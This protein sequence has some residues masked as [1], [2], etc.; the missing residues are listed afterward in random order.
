MNYIAQSACIDSAVVKDLGKAWINLQQAIGT[1]CMN[2]ENSCIGH[3]QTQQGMEFGTSRVIEI[4]LIAVKSWISQGKYNKECQKNWIVSG[5]NLKAKLIGYFK[6]FPAS[7][8]LFLVLSC[9]QFRPIQSNK[10][11]V[12]TGGGYFGP[13]GSIS[14]ESTHLPPTTLPLNM[15]A[16][17]E[18]QHSPTQGECGYT[19]K[20]ALIQIGQS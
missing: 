9:F 10:S 5:N 13:L 12:D 15:A 6:V 7:S 8:S 16:A 19:L 11:D 20:T 17:G 1:I 18:I 2:P 3:F 14:C 4:I